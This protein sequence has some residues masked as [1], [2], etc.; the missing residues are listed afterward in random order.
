MKDVREYET[1]EG[2]RMGVLIFRGSI[3]DSMLTCVRGRGR[4]G[5]ASRRLMCLIRCTLCV[6]AAERRMIHWNEGN[7]MCAGNGSPHYNHCRTSFQPFVMIGIL[8]LLTV[9]SFVFLFGFCR[10]NSHV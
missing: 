2:R 4:I 6:M 9:L 1:G 10:C 8:I 7:D 3:R 5:S